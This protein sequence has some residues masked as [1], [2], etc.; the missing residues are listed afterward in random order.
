MADNENK[1]ISIEDV[2][3]LR[4]DLQNLIDTDVYLNS[5]NERYIRDL[6]QFYDSNFDKKKEDLEEILRTNEHMRNVFKGIGDAFKEQVDALSEID[7]LTQSITNNGSI[8]KDDMESLLPLLIKYKSLT[9]E[10]DVI[11]SKGSSINE[12]EK[13]QLQ[14]KEQLLKEIENE[15]TKS[16]SGTKLLYDYHSADSDELRRIC[17]IYDDLNKKLQTNLE[18]Q[19]ENNRTIIEGKKI[20]EKQNKEKERNSWKTGYKVIDNF[21]FKGRYLAG[22]GDNEEELI[23]R[24]NH[25][26][27]LK[28]LLNVLK[29]VV[30]QSFD[31]WREIDQ[32]TTDFGRKM[33]M[34]R[35]QMSDFREYTIDSYSAIARKLGMESKELF[36][37]QEQFSENTQ[38]AVMLTEDQITSIAGLSRYVGDEAVSLAEQNLDVLTGGNADATVDYLAK[39]MAKATREGL[40]IKAYSEAFAKNMKLAS[41][42][43]FKD[44]INGIQRMT[45]L[46]QRLKVDMAS[47]ASAMDK[48]GTIESSIETGAQIQVLG[49]SFANNFGNPMQAMAESL[50]DPEAFTKRI[51]NTVTPLVRFNEKTGEYELS[52]TDKLRINAFA[53]SLGMDYQEVINMGTQ[54]HKLSQIKST[55]NTNNDFSEEDWSYIANKAQYNAEHNAWMIRTPDGKDIKVNDIRN[56]E[57][58]NE[59]K[60][61]DDTDKLIASRI[62]GIHDILSNKFDDDKAFNEEV[63]SI[64]ES[65]KLTGAKIVNG[66]MSIA[67]VGSAIATWMAVNK[68][69]NIGGAFGNM[70]GGLKGNNPTGKPI[71]VQ[72]TLAKGRKNINS[73]IKR[74]KAGYRLYNKKAFRGQFGKI[75]GVVSI[76]IGALDALTE[77]N[78]HNDRKDEILQNDNL[79]LKE[80]ALEIKKSEKERN[81][82]IGGAAVGTATGLYGAKLGATIGAVGGPVGMAIGGLIG[83]AIGYF[84]GDKIGQGIGGLISTNG[85]DDVEEYENNDKKENTRIALANNKSL[86]NVESDVYYIASVM[87]SQKPQNSQVYAGVNNFNHTQVA[88]TNGY[89]SSSNSMNID[90]NKI[91]VGVSG[92]IDLQTPSGEG[93]DI[94]ADKWLSIPKVKQEI[95]AIVNKG[96]NFAIN[97]GIRE[98]NYNTKT[99]SV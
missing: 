92:K 3:K 78:N 36:K 38:R 37:F 65:L 97:G 41:K 4:E 35:Q 11:K 85:K 27:M 5:K 2:K 54:E 63:I 75:G 48:F 43:N 95:I 73:T 10:I 13:N 62:S 61:T 74:G 39:G 96:A 20:I 50:L 45:L 68:L 21:N 89:L 77:W 29:T 22:A 72:E 76:G 64:T 79:S 40:H 53:K 88:Q 69:T 26:T 91:Q 90:F 59:I 70:M 71:T 33:G 25:I 9:E 51:M 28:E 82:G 57:A 56:K 66:I 8:Q 18:T 46:T 14:Y 15:I 32:M 83:G 6:I 60:K 86:N 42:Y 7:S 24:K 47:I 1:N 30:S 99:T 94:R 12:D 93:F 80:K 19:R 34:N 23:H 67:G 55:V 98:N 16:V 31:K 84:A 17:E 49:G 87:S 58:L 81:K 44:G 52:P